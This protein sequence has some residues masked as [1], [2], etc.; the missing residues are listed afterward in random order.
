MLQ[1]QTRFHR[2]FSRISV[3]FVLIAAIVD[4]MTCT[5]SLS[6]PGK[7]SVRAPCAEANST[8]NNASEPDVHHSSINVA[9]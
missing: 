1:V 2:R 8:E 4:A 5:A 3:Q 6:C 9:L 7:V